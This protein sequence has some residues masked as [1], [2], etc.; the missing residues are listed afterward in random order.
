VRWGYKAEV[1]AAGSQWLLTTGTDQTT[2]WIVN[3]VDSNLAFFKAT[4]LWVDAG[5]F[6]MS[7]NHSWIQVQFIDVTYP[8]NSD[9]DT[10]VTYS[11]NVPLTLK[12]EAG[13]QIF[14]MGDSFA[15]S[16]NVN[17]TETQAAITR[18]IIEGAVFAA[19][20]LLAIAG[21][22]IE[23]LSAGTEVLEVS[24]DGGNALVD[25][26]VFENVEDENPEANEENEE[27][28]GNAAAEQSGGKWTNIKNAFKAPRWKFV[29]WLAALAGS[30]VGVDK[31][32]DEILKNAAIH[33][34]Q[35]VPGFDDFAETA[36]KPYSFTGVPGF[37]LDSAALAGSLQIGF[38]VKATPGSEG[39]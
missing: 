35:A 18:E 11:E 4:S 31:L 15:R 20:S 34:W 5:K 21:P 17:V 6:Q 33:D 24:E 13:K 28:A 36:I 29:G 7:L 39:R 22:I 8:A 16:L 14:W 25:E 26:E 37:A 30:V 23:G 9:Y 12:T 3:K 38:K 1:T 2:E 27:D 32:V 19:L 10:H